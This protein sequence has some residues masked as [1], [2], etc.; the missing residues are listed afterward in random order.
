MRNYAMRKQRRD[1][2]NAR[3]SRRPEPAEPLEPVTDCRRPIDIDLSCVGG[4]R[5]TL[6]PRDGYHSW[7]LV[8]AS[9]QKTKKAALKTL[10]RGLADELPRMRAPRACG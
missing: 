3:W 1:A 6:V 7:W 5:W 4:K 10:L 8:D 9:G 2:A